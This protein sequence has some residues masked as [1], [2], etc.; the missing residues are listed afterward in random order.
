M[1][2]PKDLIYFGKDDKKVAIP[3]PLVIRKIM[4]RLKEDQREASLQ[5][6]WCGH[7]FIQHL[8][9]KYEEKE[10]TNLNQI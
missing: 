7:E 2:T 6:K 9:D 8:E 1:E 4:S 10:S 3:Y 5:T